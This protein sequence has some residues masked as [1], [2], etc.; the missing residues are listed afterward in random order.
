MAPP[1]KRCCRCVPPHGS[2]R[3]AGDD[4]AAP[5]SRSGFR[6]RAERQILSLDAFVPRWWSRE[7]VLVSNMNIRCINDGTALSCVALFLP[8]ARNSAPSLTAGAPF[9]VCKVLPRWSHGACY[10]ACEACTPITPF[11]YGYSFDIQTREG[12]RPV[13]RGVRDAA[14]QVAAIELL[15]WWPGASS[16]WRC[17]ALARMKRHRCHRRP[18]AIRKDG[19]M[20]RSEQSKRNYVPSTNS[21]VFGSWKL[22]G[23]AALLPL[24]GRSA[25]YPALR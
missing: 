14:K 10:V 2:A 20:A 12:C 3:A 18:R 13:R 4:A 17:M 22:S 23:G 25:I 9:G 19:Q 1:A 5:L 24:P 21:Q 11:I 6:R 7:R 16:I 15:N 8:Q